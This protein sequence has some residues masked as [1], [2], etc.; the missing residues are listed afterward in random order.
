M[1]KV[2]IDLY[3]TVMPFIKLLEDDTKAVV[4]PTGVAM[5]CGLDVYDKT[6]SGCGLGWRRGVWCMRDVRVMINEEL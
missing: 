2:A 3:P 6:Q 4:F 1:T 5:I